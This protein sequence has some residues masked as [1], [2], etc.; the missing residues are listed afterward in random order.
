MIKVKNLNPTPHYNCACGTWLKHWQ[1]FST[2]KAP[3]CAA[4][5]CVEKATVGTHIQKA[6]SADIAW[7]VVPFCEQHSQS[8][9][10]MQIADN[11]KLV[12]ASPQHTCERW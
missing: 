2:L 5:N 4:A 11:Y 1:K 3:I 8:T 7:Y 6:D 10:E 9:A 12:I